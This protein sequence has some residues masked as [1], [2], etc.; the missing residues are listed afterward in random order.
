M[1]ELKERISK[2]GKKAIIIAISFFILIIIIIFGG[3]FLYNKFFYKRSYTEIEDI[4]LNAAKS[5][6]KQHKDDLPKELNQSVTLSVDDLVREEEMQD[7]SEYT[8]DKS[9]QCVGN[10][11]VTLMNQNYRYTPILDCDNKYTTVKFI[12]YI[13]EKAPIVENGN[14]LYNLNE[15]LVYRGDNVNNYIKLSGKMYRIVKFSSD[16][17][18]IIYTDKSDAV[19][20]DNRYNIEKN[21]AYGINDYSVSKVRDYLNKVYSNSTFFDDDAKMLVVPYSLNIGKRSIK[22]TDK[23]G[24]IEKGA[25][26]ENQFIG[27]LPIYDFMNASLDVNCTTAVSPSCVN[28]NFLS[29]FQAEWWSVTGSKLNTYN[30]Y[31]ISGNGSTVFANGLGVARY[32]LHLAKDA[33]YVSGDGTSDNPYIVK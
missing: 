15:E 31:R 14:G 20:W 25:V 3:A 4:M 11:I 1:K 18:V 29:K 2:L 9:L 10:I 30:V 16:E 28:Y 32:V 8:K 19:V 6:M 7:I 27:L 5:H 17:A 23:S 13:K 12:D 26:M 33:I 24:Q 22:D 21:G